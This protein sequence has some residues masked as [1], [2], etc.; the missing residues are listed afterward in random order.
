MGTKNIIGE[1]TI[2][3]SKVITES[4]LP[5][6]NFSGS[7]NDLTDKPTIPTRVS[8]LENDKGYLT[9]YTENDPTVPSHVKGIT[10]TDIANWNNKSTFD[11]NYDNLT[12]K[13]TIPTVPTNIGAFENDKG[14]LTS[15]TETDPTVPNHVK[16]ITE[17]NISSWNA[18]SDFSGSYN[19]L[20]DK[21]TIPSV[22]GL[23]TETYVDNKVATLVDSAPE[24]LNTL[25]ELA[26]ALNN[27]E[28]AYDALLETV[29]GKA[30]KSSLATVATSGSYNDLSNKPTIPTVPTKVSSFE[31]DKGYLTS[32]TETDPTVPNHVKSITTTDISNWN[33]K[34]TFDGNYN[35]LTNKPTIP[36]DTGAT[37]VE[38]TGSGNAVTT[39]SYDSDTRKITL[40]KDATY[41]NY[42]LPAAGNSLGGVKSGGDVTITDGVITVNDDSHNHIIGNVD[43]L[44]DALGARL[45]KTTYETSKELACGSNGKVCL[46]KFSAYDTNITI[47]INSTTDSTYHAII[48][49]QSQNIAANSTNGTATCQVYGDADNHITDLLTIFRPY[50]SSDRFIEVY[51]NLPAYSKN[52]IHVQAVNLKEGGMTNVLTSVDGI[53]TSITGKT[54]VWPH[55]VLLANFI[56]NGITDIYTAYE[57]N[58]SGVSAD[59]S[60][61]S[62]DSDFMIL[63]ERDGGVGETAYG[64]LSQLLPIVAGDNVHFTVEGTETGYEVV[65]I[66]ATGGS[67]WYTGTAITGTSTTATIFSSSGITSAIVGDMYLNTSTG[68][69]YKCT[70]AGAADVAKW[71]YVCSL[72]GA[73]GSA[74]DS[75]VSAT[76]TEVQ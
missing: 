27:H 14:Y 61:I 76:I 75:I 31:N 74:G 63:D 26:T 43:G 52:L 41:N 55:N 65:K 13:P 22:S 59:T 40:I 29:G 28:D 58:I 30:D 56:P 34:S 3:G 50:G 39:A 33:N 44:Q 71:V 1:L 36:I 16:G 48:I 11:G 17:A 38:V 2:N 25:G 24:A 47:E 19:D 8:D 64:N 62:W 6:D 69:V 46:G 20:T 73:T 21:P 68:Y 4:T 35:S 72:K 57:Q 12:N 54:K 53:P 32:Y 7:Y 42:S 37:G 9:T 51:A 5:A 15:Y 49:I 10:T 60:G 70:V 23:A 67:K 66:N 45:E 18:K